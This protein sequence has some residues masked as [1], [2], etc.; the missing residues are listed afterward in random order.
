MRNNSARLSAAAAFTRA[1]RLRC[2]RCG[3]GK[4]FSGWLKMYSRCPNCT[5]RYERGPGYFLGSTY[6]NYGVTAFLL[7]VMYVTCRFG[8]GIDNPMLIVFLLAF[9]VLFPL[10][11]FRYARSFWLAFDCY[12]DTSDTQTPESLRIPASRHAETPDASERSTVD[13]QSGAAD[14]NHGD[15]N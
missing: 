11:F 3:G 13:A 15:S 8:F 12:L 1:L 10:F 14:D 6:V 9:C 4:L 7:T 5:L 2:P